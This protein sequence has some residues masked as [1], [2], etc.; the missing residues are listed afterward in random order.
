MGKKYFTVPFHLFIAIVLFT[1]IIPNNTIA[2]PNVGRSI[3]ASI[4]LGLSAPYDDV[5]LSGSGFYAQGE[6]IF[7]ISKWF[8]VRPYAGVIFT[9]PNENT[10]LPEYKVTSDAFLFG[11]KARIV[12][13]IPYVAPYFEVGVGGSI[14]KFE[15]YTPFTNLKKNGFL[16]HI[17]VSLGLALGKN[18]SVELEFTYYYHPAVEQ[19]SG[20]L[21][22]GLKFPL[23]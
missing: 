1:L 15:T 5:D 21:A 2:Q 13:P 16:M 8:G 18:H 20:A 19:Y 23:K 7:G 17:P 11:G 12:A 22:F 14:G 4:G 10:N 6:Y 3:K 9:S